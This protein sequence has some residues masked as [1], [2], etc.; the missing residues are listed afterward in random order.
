MLAQLRAKGADVAQETQ[1]HGGRRV[2][3]GINVKRITEI[4]R[5]QRSFKSLSP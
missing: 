2:Y 5:R 1:G 3:A 4:V